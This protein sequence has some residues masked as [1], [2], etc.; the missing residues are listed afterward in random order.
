V[1]YNSRRGSDHNY[2]INVTGKGRGAGIYD[3]EANAMFS[4]SSSVVN[5]GVQHSALPCNHQPYLQSSLCNQL[6][7]V[8]VQATAH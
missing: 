6:Q 7:W 3:P 8:P 1:F 5:T 2:Q 4:I